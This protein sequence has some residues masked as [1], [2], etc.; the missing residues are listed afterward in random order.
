MGFGS[1]TDFVRP[2]PALP[3]ARSRRI[4]LIP[5]G[6]N[7]RRDI[8]RPYPIVVTIAQLPSINCLNSSIRNAKSTIPE[9]VD[10]CQIR[11]ERKSL[12]GCMFM[13]EY[14]TFLLKILSQCLLNLNLRKGKWF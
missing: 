6:S 13:L 9:I 1:E 2:G 10:L 11:L 5:T 7:R 14:T 3:G 8:P 12:P 4:R